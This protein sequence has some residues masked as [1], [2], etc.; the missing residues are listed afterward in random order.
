MGTTVFKMVN[1]ILEFLF[2]FSFK[3][4]QKDIPFWRMLQTLQQSN[5]SEASL[6]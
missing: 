1:A 5:F 2:I 4:I 3:K 6:D